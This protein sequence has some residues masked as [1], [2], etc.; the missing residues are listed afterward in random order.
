MSE[1]GGSLASAPLMQFHFS[2]QIEQ[3]DFGVV[4]SG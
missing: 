3:Q 1:Y 4:R 2:R